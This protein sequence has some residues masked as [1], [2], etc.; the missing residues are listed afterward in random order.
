MIGRLSWGILAMALLV[1]PARAEPVEEMLKLV[2]DSALGLVAVNRPAEV[3]VK[4]QEIAKQL[5]MPAPSPLTLLKAVAGIREGLDEKGTVAL[6]LLPQAGSA[7]P[8][9]VV[10]APVSDYDKFIAPLAPADAKAAVTLIRIGG[11]PVLAR[12]IGGFVAMSDERYRDALESLQAAAAVA[13]PLQPWQEWVAKNDVV[14]LAFR[15]GIEILSARAQEG[16]KTVE[17]TLDR[18]SGAKPELKEQM[19]SA[20]AVFRVYG[21]AVRAVERNC[22]SFGLA[23]RRDAQ[24]TIRVA[25]R[26]RML[27]DSRWGKSLVGA[28]RAG[29]PLAGL[30]DGPFLLA[31]GG[32]LPKDAMEAMMKFSIQMMKTMPGAFGVEDNQI[33]EMFGELMKTMRSVRGMA[34]VLGVPEK[35]QSLYGNTV[36]VMEVDDAKQFL[37]DYEKAMAD[38][39]RA[40]SKAK[41]PM[42]QQIEMKKIKVAGVDGLELVVKMPQLPA[43][44]PPQAAKIMEMIVGKEGSLTAWIAPAGDKRIVFGYVHK[45][46]VER[47]IAAIKQDAPGLSAAPEV[48][49]AAAILP[50][51]AVWVAYWSP[52]GTAE[53]INCVIPRLVPKAE[54][55]DSRA[56]ALPEFPQTPPLAFSISTAPGEVQTEMI[57][58]SEVV[59]AL[60]QYIPKLRAM[61]KPPSRN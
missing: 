26:T 48:K 49:K 58:P 56:I 24:G 41:G 21:K 60:G 9:P 35:D 39:A 46:N 8:A 59:K 30:P 52:R 25:T 47:A 14:L 7:G 17:A 4:L 51:D 43:G 10:L 55:G 11:K 38:Y 32:P 29:D 50:K 16:L 27:A 5:Q 18:V 12:R 34:M 54:D 3:D 19:Q 61:R 42:V 23:L 20:V 13:K 37:A 36:A 44:S 1:L 57:V 33:D 6:L 22:E 53:F 40:M 28:K 45:A 15:P 31:G 2:P